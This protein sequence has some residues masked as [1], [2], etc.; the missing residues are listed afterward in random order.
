MYEYMYTELNK[1]V[2]SFYQFVSVIVGVH[3]KTWS[4]S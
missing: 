1:H 2:F 3:I 4:P